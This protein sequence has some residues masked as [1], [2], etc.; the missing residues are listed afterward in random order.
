MEDMMIVDDGKLLFYSFDTNGSLD[1]DFN[2][3]GGNNLVCLYNYYMILLNSEG[4]YDIQML[5]EKYIKEL[6]FYVDYTLSFQN[7]IDEYNDNKAPGH[8]VEI[9]DEGIENKRILNFFV[10]NG[11]LIQKQKTL[12]KK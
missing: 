9:I 5:I 4:L 1:L 12:I 2:I 3:I 6:N 8:I 11:L 10:E 7:S